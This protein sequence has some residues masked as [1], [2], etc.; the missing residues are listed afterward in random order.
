MGF[1][2][3]DV[4]S[5]YDAEEASSSMFDV[6]ANPANKNM[7]PQNG[8]G[9]IADGKIGKARGTLGETAHFRRNVDL[10]G[11]QFDVRGLVSMSILGWCRVTSL[12]QSP[13][14]WSVHDTG[15]A[16]RQAW[17]MHAN[18]AGGA[19]NQVPAFAMLDGI[20]IFNSKIVKATVTGP[21]MTVNVWHMV[22][23]GWNH[24]T[25]KMRCF[26]GDG[27]DPTGNT[28]YYA[29]A[30]GFVAG[31]GFTVDFQ[32][33]FCAGF[34]AGGVNGDFVQIDHVSYWKDRALTEDEFLDHWQGGTA[35]LFSE[36]GS[37]PGRGAGVAD[38]DS[39]HYYWSK[40]RARE[41]KERFLI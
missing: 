33:N 28:T 5:Q 3:T 10:D 17:Q 30:D 13:F 6:K 26:W 12:T 21:S 24:V 38:N 1:P 34:R 37:D 35:L 9:S 40:R 18:N 11:T 4:N 39:Y 16:N 2:Y 29:E 20:T 36:F 23:G 31:F 7:V 22:G 25:N 27:N 8:P 15:A 32:Q 41:A 14:F 19:G